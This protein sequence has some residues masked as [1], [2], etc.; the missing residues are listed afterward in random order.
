MF[1]I[2]VSVPV[3]LALVFLNWFLPS[4][5]LKFV[6]FIQLI[7][8]NRIFALNAFLLCIYLQMLCILLIAWMH[9]AP[10]LTS[11]TQVD[12]CMKDV[13]ENIST[14][15]V[16][17]SQREKIISRTVWLANRQN[18]IILIFASYAGAK[19]RHMQSCSKRL[20]SRGS[21][22][23]SINNYLRKVPQRSYRCGSSCVYLCLLQ[24]VIFVF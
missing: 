13:T 10:M 8:L 5:M 19:A 16:K 24:L 20:Q 15:T 6:L 23:H 14:W 3:L 12:I 17:I 7:K 2:L 9:H 4:S 11:A 1:P 18:W 22:P 21:A